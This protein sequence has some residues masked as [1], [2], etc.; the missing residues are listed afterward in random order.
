MHIFDHFLTTEQFTSGKCIFILFLVL[1]DILTCM[2][3]PFPT[4]FYPAHLQELQNNVKSDL[5]QKVLSPKSF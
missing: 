5:S 3:Q 2:L 1:F 4:L